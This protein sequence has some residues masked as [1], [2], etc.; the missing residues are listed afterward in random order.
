[1]AET[2]KI[3]VIAGDGIGPEVVG[4]AIKVIKKVE[5]LYEYRFEFE[6]GLFGGIAID[7]KGT[8]LPQ[9]TLE[10]CQ[11]ADAVLLGAVGGPK[12]DNNSKELRPETGLLGIR[13]ALGLF[14]NIRPATVFDCL[15]DASTLKPEVLEGTDLIVVRELT[16]GIYFGEKFRREGEHGQEAVD[17]CVYNVQEVE[18][19]VRQAFDIAMTRGKRL[20]SVDKANVLETSRLWR[21]VVNR[22]APEYPEVELEHVLVDN[23]AMQL[24]RRPSSFDVIVTENM[25]G[26]ILSD[27]AAMLT[28]SIGMLSSASLGEGSFGLYEPVHGSAPD[29][30]GQGISNP[31]ATIL[32]VALMFRLTFG[33]ADA[34]Q[35]IE[36]AVKEVLDAGHRTGDIAV[37]K[38]KAIGTEEMGR[39]IVEA[40]R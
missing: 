35:A 6:H 8:P 29:I 4:E 31:I 25:F 16:G 28:G 39:L 26:D 20:A 14:S 37:D 18:R 21:E 5:E 9:E 13:K 19:I 32:S 17:T 15:K 34:A 30:A 12:W 36:D 24:L 3:A 23:C 40:L 22:I 10:M 2:K 38:S 33:Y 27:E 7:E 11:K 1:M